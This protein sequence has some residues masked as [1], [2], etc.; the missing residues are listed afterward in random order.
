[1]LGFRVLTDDPATCS[2]FCDRA[3]IPAQR[4]FGGQPGARGALLIN[5]KAP[6]RPK[7]EQVLQPGDLIELF[8]PGAG[9]PKRACALPTRGGASTR[10]AQAPLSAVLHRNAERRRQ[11]RPDAVMAG[12]T[13]TRGWDTD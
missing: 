6:E 1:M 5:G 7:A 11:L 9:R 10:P 12:L 2:V 3:A 4:F 8:M 13:P